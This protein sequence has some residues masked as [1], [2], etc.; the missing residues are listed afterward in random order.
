MI[1]MY[2]LHI[3]AWWYVMY[4]MQQQVG[5]YLFCLR[6]PP[7]YTYNF[8]IALLWSLRVVEDEALLQSEVEQ[9]WREKVHTALGH[10]STD[11]LPVVI[12]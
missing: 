11:S 12:W 9:D 8:N 2:I 1:H 10:G 4:C 7:Q 5:W 3:G 6:L